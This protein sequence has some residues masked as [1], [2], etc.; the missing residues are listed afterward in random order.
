MS[1]Q[2]PIRL[3]RYL[4]L[5]GV[6]SRREAEDL[7]KAGKVS[8]NGQK[9]NKLGTKVV[10]GEDTVRMGRK[11]IEYAPAEVLLFHKPRGYLC[12]Q[13]KR[14]P[15]ESIYDLNPDLKPFPVTVGLEKNSQGLILLTNDG[16]LH[17]RIS[18]SL[19]GLERVFHVRMKEK[20]SDKT[21]KR[22]EKGVQLDGEQ[23]VLRSLKYLKADKTFHWYQFTMRDLRDKSLTK[24][25]KNLQH[26][27][28]KQMQVGF[29][30][31]RD[32]L[33]RK[34][35]GRQCT[36]KEIEGLKKLIGLD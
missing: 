25:F 4:A 34:G 12:N 13:D 23:I 16:V 36:T 10:P 35:K 14:Y 27:L 33:L 6:A 29:A 30:N 28:Q 19:R 17:Q 11:L 31:I 22:L 32:D 7:I 21:I 9:L 3:Q 20:M 8:V 1:A 18:A 24:L 26:P 2:E 5:A 15:G